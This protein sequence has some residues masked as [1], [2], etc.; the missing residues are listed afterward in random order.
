MS[1]RDA[2]KPGKVIKM[3]N[4]GKYVIC[5]KIAEGGLS[6]VYSAKTETNDYP[7]IIKEF[8]PARYAKRAK[9]KFRANDGTILEE[10]DRIYPEEN[11][12]ER[13]E[14]CLRAFEQEG[15][16]GSS[17]REHSFQM[18]PFSDCGTGY[19]VL[20][21]WSADSCSFYDLA[22]G[23]DSKRPASIDPVFTDLGRVRFALSAVSSLLSA[24]S[25]MHA[26]NMLHLDISAQN[27][28][29]AGH[30]RDTPENGAA[31]L[32]DFGCSVL[33]SDGVYPAEYALSNTR[34][35]A[36]PE[37]S[38]EN[39]KLSP[40]TDIYSVGRLLAFLCFGQRVLYQCTDLATRIKCLKIPERYRQLLQTLILKA[41]AKD[42]L[43]RY[44]SAAEMQSAVGELL[45][46]IPANPINPD[47]SDAFSLYSL[48]S[49]L[50]GSLDTRYSWAHEL[51]DRRN[52]ADAK[53]LAKITETIHHPVANLPA[54]HFKDDETFL[55]TILPGCIFNCLWEHISNEAD[56]ESAIRAVMSGNYPEEWKPEI[57]SVLVA[58]PYAIRGLFACCKEVLTAEQPLQDG[59]DFLFELPG[60]DIKYFRDC[61][62]KCAPAGAYKDLALLVLFALLGKGNRGFEAFANH[63]PS[64]IGK[65]WR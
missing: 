8:F 14:R 13:F 53:I 64:N 29:W 54:G 5:Q 45:R 31:F 33:M 39:G 42:P 43:Q 18:I 59:I 26:Q 38:T 21:R 16:L 58:V 41:T 10:K 40:A 9:K 60:A 1:D 19:A 20:P 47:N 24:V 7:V 37:Y 35:Y 28:V 25:S 32:T 62:M 52:V 63:S 50:E 51:C 23:W 55:R 2:L 12:E 65:M 48:K 46:A 36:A 22:E 44:P 49:M 61:F 57:G 11:Y 15:R 30:N 17:A 56:R 3:P 27:V 34:D 4:G 6:L